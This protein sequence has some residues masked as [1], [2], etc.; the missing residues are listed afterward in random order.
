[1]AAGALVPDDLMIGIIQ[2][3]RWTRPTR[4]RA[5]SWT[6][7]RARVVQAEKLDGIWS[8]MAR[9]MGPPGSSTARP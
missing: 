7:S 2:R 5:S 3:P 9:G 4:R 1:M 8:G 6:A